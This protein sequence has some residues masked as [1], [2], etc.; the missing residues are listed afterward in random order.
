MNLKLFKLINNKELKRK[1]YLNPYFAL[2]SAIFNKVTFQC[3]AKPCHCDSL[4]T[5]LLFVSEAP[6]TVQSVRA[7]WLELNAFFFIL[8]CASLETERRHGTYSWILMQISDYCVISKLS[9]LLCLLKT[10]F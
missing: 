2:T 4:I 6:P 3:K 8:N 10:S 9:K 1:D 7:D 5:F